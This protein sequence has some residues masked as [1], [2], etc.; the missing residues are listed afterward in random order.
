MDSL[1]SYLDGKAIKVR[2]YGEGQKE[3]E[4]K[5]VEHYFQAMKTVVVAERLSIISLSTPGKAKRAGTKVLMRDGWDYMKDGIMYIG[6]K[7]K[8]NQHPELISQLLAVDEEIVED[9]NWGDRYWGKVDGMGL[10]V[11]GELLTSLRDSYI[12]G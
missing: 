5:T 2:L 3:D 10:N 4:Y 9:N 8:F 11:L 12:E 6:L 7:T 1:H